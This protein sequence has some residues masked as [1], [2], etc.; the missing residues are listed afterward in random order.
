MKKLELRLHAKLGGHSIEEFIEKLK[1]DRDLLDEEKGQMVA[2]NKGS[3]KAKGRGRKLTEEYVT[4]PKRKCFSMIDLM[5]GR[6]LE[7]DQRQIMTDP[8]NYEDKL[9]YENQANPFVRGPK[10]RDYDDPE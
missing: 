3:Q 8:L 2:P 4:P 1:K 7:Q 5:D 10:N 6:E 9:K